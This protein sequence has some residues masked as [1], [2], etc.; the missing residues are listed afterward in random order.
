[1]THP[2]SGTGPVRSGLDVLA[3][4][5]SLLQGSRYGLLCHQ[6]SVDSALRFAVDALVDC[7]AGELCALFGPEHGITGE[8]QDM[9]AVP[10]S[11]DQR[12]G[13]PVHSLYGSGEETLEPALETLRGLDFLLVDLQ[14]VGSRYY[15]FAASMG[16]ALQACAKTGVR[17]I[18]LDRP[19]P[20][21]GVALE[22]NLV[23]AGWRSFVGRYPV[24]V[25]HGLTMGELALLYSGPFGEGGEMQVVPME[26]WR[27]DMWFDETGLPWVPPSP[28]MPTLDTAAVYPGSCLIEGTN[29]SEGRGTT[30]PFELVG[31][32]FLDP[33][34]FARALRSERLA[35]V[36]FRPVRFTPAFHKWAGQSCGGVQIHVI[37][38]ERFRPFRTGLALLICARDL[39]PREFDWRREP[40]EFVSDRLAIDL[41]LGDDGLRLAL[42]SGAPLDELESSWHD[43]LAS[44]SPLHE[45]V[46]LY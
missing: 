10:A 33:E 24:P 7:G 32:P 25:R 40:Y 43:E 41:L 2:A 39:A 31:A 20:I 46:R 11:R 19:N 27:R 5:P 38:R 18:V 30:R 28:N 34:A 22:G 29:L 8:A 12:T 21:G 1:M 36:A 13:L 6:A 3:H 45:R 42:E 35:G 37:D 17:L 44:F 26:G 9:V 4:A 23:R 16:A 15:T 14:D